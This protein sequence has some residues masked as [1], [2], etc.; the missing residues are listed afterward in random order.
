MTPERLRQIEE[1][2]H[3]A[4]ERE[5]EQR[6][7]FHQVIAETKLSVRQ[8]QDSLKFFED[9]KLKGVAYP[10]SEKVHPHL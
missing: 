7:V 2:Y 3:S 10:G 9:Q 1:L 6:A 4:R 8:L 5:P